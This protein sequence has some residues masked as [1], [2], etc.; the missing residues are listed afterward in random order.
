MPTSDQK[1][2]YTARFRYTQCQKNG[3]TINFK[4]SG[5]SK[6]D[7][8]TIDDC[9]WDKNRESILFIIFNDVI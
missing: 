4:Y 9:Q 5:V 1:E 3:K 2:V 6:Q 8:Q 7:T